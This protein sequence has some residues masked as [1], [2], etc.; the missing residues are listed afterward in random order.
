M[1]KTV[2]R[3]YRKSAN[4]RRTKKTV[5][6]KR[7]A[8][9]AQK[10]APPK[11]VKARNMKARVAKVEHYDIRPLRKHVA[12]LCREW[13][14][15]ERALDRAFD[16]DDARTMRMHERYMEKIE[17]EMKRIAEVTEVLPWHTGH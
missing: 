2:K 4:G 7:Q 15:E 5:T 12:R 16:K 17:R 6:A 9:S 1:K 13:R 8:R 11:L 10:V 14:R 3:T